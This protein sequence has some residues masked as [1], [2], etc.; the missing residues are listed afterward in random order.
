MLLPMMFC[1]TTTKMAGVDAGGN[2]DPKVDADG[3]IIIRA[4]GMGAAE[5]GG[6][7]VVEMALRG[8]AFDRIEEEKRGQEGAGAGKNYN[9][10][11]ADA[12]DLIA[13]DASINIQ[14]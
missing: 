13:D 3:I 14:L 8:I 2:P 11:D 4:I 12:V 5:N 10:N 1:F 6:R 9:T 7:A